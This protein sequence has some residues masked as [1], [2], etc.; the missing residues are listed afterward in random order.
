MEE[1]QTGYLRKGRLSN[2]ERLIIL[3]ELGEIA[4]DR[5]DRYI[6]SNKQGYNLDLLKGGLQYIPN[7]QT[8]ENIYY[9]DT[10]SEE[11]NK[12]S[13]FFEYGTG[14]YNTEFKH[15][16]FIKPK[17]SKYL[18]FIGTNQYA[19]VTV[20][21]QKVKGV[22]PIMMFQKTVKSMAQD[23]EYLQRDIRFWHGF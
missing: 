5:Y 8:F 18:K 20:F 14:I 12:I 7:I 3:Q 1:V 13:R 2:A 19:G 17:N 21:A 10:G 16:T 9:V 22:R 15:S 6:E 4:S 11:L 23:R